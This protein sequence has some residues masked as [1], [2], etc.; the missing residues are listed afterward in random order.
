MSDD[1]PKLSRS[2]QIMVAKLIRLIAGGHTGRIEL[3]TN[4]GGVESMTASE[5]W[6][7]KDVER[8]G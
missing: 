8:E 2:A 4:R 6:V 1:L 3:V 7:P 5:R